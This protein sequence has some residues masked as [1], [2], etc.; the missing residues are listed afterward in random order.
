MLD[1]NDNNT[2]D[3]DILRGLEGSSDESEEEHSDAEYSDEEQ[4]EENSEA[5]NC[6]NK[7]LSF[8]AFFIIKTRMS[9]KKKE[10]RKKYTVI[11]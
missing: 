1:Q 7:S 2:D 9:L 8:C 11:N 4:S 3:L 6:S 5:G 10:K